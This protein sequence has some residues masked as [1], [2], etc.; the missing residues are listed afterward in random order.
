MLVVRH[1]SSTLLGMLSSL[2]GPKPQANKAIGVFPKSFRRAELVWTTSHRDQWIHV[3]LSSK[4]MKYFAHSNNLTL[5][6]N[7]LFLRRGISRSR[8][9]PQSKWHG[10]PAY[11]GWGYCSY[12]SLPL[13]R[14][15]LDYRPDYFC[16]RWI[17]YSLAE[18]LIVAVKLMVMV[19]CRIA[20]VEYMDLMD[21]YGV[22]GV[23]KERRVIAMGEGNC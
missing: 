4:T 6:P 2:G 13:H 5:Y 16:Q 23:Q 8:G 9:I 17:H 3:S 21:S 14:W 22:V 10:Q 19:I 15:C 7:S 18:F 20:V 12:H 11:Y 1:P